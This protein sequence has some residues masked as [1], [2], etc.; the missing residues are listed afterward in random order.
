M[1]TKVLFISML[2]PL[3]SSRTA[4][5]QT[6][7]F[8]FNKF[9]QD[10]EFQV[11][12][13]SCAKYSDYA[14]IEDELKYIEKKIIYWGH[15][16]DNRL[17]KLINLESRYNPFNRNANL[18]S[19]TTEM[20]I[21]QNLQEYVMSGFKPD[22]I[23][24][25]WTEMVVLAKKIKNKYPDILLVASEHDVTLVGYKRKSEFYKGFKRLLWQQKYRHEKKVELSSL[26]KCDLVLPHN[27]DNKEILVENGIDGDK[28]VGLVPYYHN[29]KDL[30]RVNTGKDIL[31][32]GAMNR[33]ENIIS[34][35]WFIK[36][37]MPLLEDIDCRFVVLGNNPQNELK[38]HEN[39]RV[40]FTGFVED[41]SLFF[42][43]SRCFVAPLLLGA[44]IKIK[45]LEAL[46]SGIPVLTNAIGIE[47]IPVIAD[48]DYYHCDTAEEYSKV[49]HDIFED[50]SVGIHVGERGQMRVCESFSPE[51]FYES[52]KKIVIS[53]VGGGKEKE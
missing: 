14:K 49:I 41:V 9:L 50:I 18:T 6:F 19:N 10:D 35:E 21:M 8:Y 44:G 40:H 11:G 51:N 31:F 39:E 25:E 29:M 23:I 32:F 42:E 16:D 17:I 43:Q 34:V 33:M 15:P 45:V 52:Y 38:E 2:P 7:C 3:H 12:L 28:V 47:G 53:L 20:R 37:V 26:K 13:I 4:G 48:C 36:N 30:I 1:K 24:L 27:S 22:V 46:S 5:E